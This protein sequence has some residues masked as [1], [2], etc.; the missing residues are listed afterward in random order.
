MSST[1]RFGDYPAGVIWLWGALT[2]YILICESFGDFRRYPNRRLMAAGSFK[3]SFLAVMCLALGTSWQELLGCWNL[4]YCQN[5]ERFLLRLIFYWFHYELKY[6]SL[7]SYCALWDQS[8]GHQFGKCSQSL[9]CLAALG[10]RANSLHSLSVSARVGRQKGGSC[11]KR[12]M[13]KRNRNFIS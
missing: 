12:S 10:Q 7:K 4:W 13:K 6:I 3:N 9:A 5:N 1:S 2:C 8:S 11:I